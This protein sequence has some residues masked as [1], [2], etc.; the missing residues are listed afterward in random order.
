MLE[1]TKDS[2]G[3]LKEAPLDPVKNPV[4][5]NEGG[6]LQVGVNEAGH[7]FGSSAPGF[8][9]GLAYQIAMATAS[10]PGDDRDLAFAGAVVAGIGPRDQIESMLAAQMAA[11]HSATMDFARR[12]RSAQ[13]LPQQE[14]AVR[15]LNQLSRTYAAQMDTLK[16]Y[17]SNGQ[18]SVTVKHVHVSEGGQAIVGDVTYQGGGDGNNGR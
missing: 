16:R 8:I 17:R 5:L 13:T 3:P 2:L 18:Q 6:V 11:V 7:A 15:Q 9:E 1:R 12:L 10:K 4:K 14:T